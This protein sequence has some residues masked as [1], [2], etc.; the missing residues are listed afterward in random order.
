MYR[1][2]FKVQAVCNS[3][4]VT[5]DDLNEYYKRYLNLSQKN[6]REK[7][8]AWFSA[9]GSLDLLTMDDIGILSA[10]YPSNLTEGR[11]TAWLSGDSMDP[12]RKSGKTYYSKEDADTILKGYNEHKKKNAIPTDI[13]KKLAK[14]VKKS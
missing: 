12:I 4:E 1:R 6:H 13:F 9:N 14:K 7:V 3:L 10:I 5:E 2:K 8:Y 11:E